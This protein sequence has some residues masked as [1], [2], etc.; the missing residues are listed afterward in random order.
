MKKLTKVLV[1]SKGMTLVETMAAIAIFAIVLTGILDLAVGN[2]ATG[3]RAEF[4]YTVY[5]LAKN[6]LETLRSMPY[7][8][9]TNAAESDVY[10]DANGVSDADGLYIRNT[11]VT[12]SYGGDPNLIGLTV[13]VD[14]IY[15]GTPSGSPTELSAI[16]YQ[17]A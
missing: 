14:Y 2:L 16:V 13:S 10:V 1:D 5:N 7:S 3:K 17:Y 8:T 15:R 9:L 6:H 4:A 12:S 11:E